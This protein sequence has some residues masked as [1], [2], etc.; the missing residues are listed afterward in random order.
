MSAPLHPSIALAWL[1]LALGCRT[2]EPS[3]SRTEASLP[4]TGVVTVLRYTT[5]E[6]GSQVPLCTMAACTRPSASGA[7]STAHVL[8]APADSPKSVT[9]PGSPPKA[10]AL[11][12]FLRSPSC[13]V[14]PEM[15]LVSTQAVTREAP[16]GVRSQIGRYR[17]LGAI[18]HGGKADVYLASAPGPLGVHKLL[19]VK[20]LRRGQDGRARRRW[21]P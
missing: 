7:P 5:D 13:S 18:G 20:Q 15:R 14:C 2:A 4:T 10:G 9:R 21:S 12:P 19:V 8:T 6:R 1:I 17:L 3:A 11:S 16:P